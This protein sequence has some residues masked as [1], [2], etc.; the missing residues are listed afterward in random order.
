MRAD[1]VDGTERVDVA[2]GQEEYKRN[3]VEAAPKET[4]QPTSTP[5]PRTTWTRPREFTVGG[6]YRVD[7][8]NLDAFDEEIKRQAERDIA[9]LRQRHVDNRA[10]DVYT[11]LYN[12]GF[13]PTERVDDLIPQW[14][15]V[16]M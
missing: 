3:C 1:K 16:R 5:G 7:A 14:S 6:L 11:L 15:K 12:G 8:S 10:E 9:R 13:L 4:A 2:A